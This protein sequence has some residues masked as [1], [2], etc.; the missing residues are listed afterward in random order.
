M[1]RCYWPYNVTLMISDWRGWRYFASWQRDVLL[2]IIMESQYL[3]PLFLLAFMPVY[4]RITSKLHEA[5]P[6]LICPKY[7]SLTFF[8]SHFPRIKDNNQGHYSNS[9]TRNFQENNPHQTFLF[10]INTKSF[11][12]HQNR[13]EFSN[14]ILALSLQF[15]RW[16]FLLFVVYFVL[17]S[18]LHSLFRGAMDAFSSF[19]DS[20]TGARNRWNYDSLKNF[21]RISPVVQNHL[22]Q[23]K[24][25]LYKKWIPPSIN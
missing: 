5:F 25:R 20:Q 10:Y 21:R 7:P 16:T 6:Y 12:F 1:S 22:K 13:L 24:E 9:T 2:V 15:S 18:F 14:N 19:F 4:L 23:V 3:N 17:F 8:N 11:Y